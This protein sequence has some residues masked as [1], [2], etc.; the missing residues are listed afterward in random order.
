MYALEQV[1]GGGDLSQVDGLFAS[2]YV[3]HD[4]SC[5]Q[6]LHGPPS[7]KQQVSLYRRAFPDLRIHVVER[8][9][10]GDTVFLRWTGDGT[11]LGGFLELEP[12]GK[13]VALHGTT[14]TRLDHG[15]AVEGWSNWEFG[16]LSRQLGVWPHS[17]DWRVPREGASH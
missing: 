4:P 3:E 6:T 13:K 15:K 12:T 1:Y 2:D 14:I 7:V 9:I 16:A 5:L 17:I 8:M 10:E 11:H